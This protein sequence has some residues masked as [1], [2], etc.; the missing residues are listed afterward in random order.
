MY[1][2]HQNSQTILAICT[3]VITALFVG[4]LR[5][6]YA[7]QY[8]PATL[9]KL[10]S[11]TAATPFQYRW[12]T[13][14]LLR[15]VT[16]VVKIDIA[17]LVR[18]YETICFATSVLA[19]T[20]YGRATGLSAKQAFMAGIAYFAIIP[21]F[22]IFQPLGRLY[23][24]Y[25]SASVPLCALALLALAQNRKWLFLAIFG[26]GLLNRES[27]VLVFALA[28]YLFRKDFRSRDHITF[29]TIGITFILSAKFLAIFLFGDNPGAG[30]L[31]LDHDIMHKG[32]PKTLESSRIYTNA[33][34]FTELDSAVL[35]ASVFGYLWLPVL[36]YRK[37]IDNAVVRNSVLLIPLSILTMF[38]VGNLNEPRIF[39]ELAP[40][41]LIAFAHITFKPTVAYPD[42]RTSFK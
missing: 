15:T 6:N 35:A 40:V 4:W 7:S 11:G 24:P 28:L 16:S 21:F 5:L 18:W 20:A 1:K 10:M 13:P 33:M 12:L 37:R 41:V 25:D 19:I 26:I 17:N 34:L 2:K 23:Y 27:I 38:F 31:S 36:I 14:F 22:F 30:V 42:S 8:G 29:L 3:I 32:L 39:C 9:E